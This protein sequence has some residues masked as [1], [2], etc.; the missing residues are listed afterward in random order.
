ME[1]EDRILHHDRS[2]IPGAV[3]M[4]FGMYNTEEEVDT[5]IEALGRISRDEYEGTY[6]LDKEAGEYRPENVHF[7]FEKYFQI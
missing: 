1:L 5:V 4:S 2:T 7:E 3:R 6:T